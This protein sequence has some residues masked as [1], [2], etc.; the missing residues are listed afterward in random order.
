MRPHRSGLILAV[1]LSSVLVGTATQETAPQKA[2][3]APWV[4]PDFPFY[5][6]VLDARH[7]GVTLPATNL[8]PRALVLNLGD[9]LWA[10]FDPDLLRVAAMWRGDGVTPKALAPG[11]Y[12][13]PDKKTPGGQTPA[14]EPQGA[15]WVANGIY[16][17]WQAGDRLSLTD[18]REPAP[19]PEE[20]G[21]GPIPETTGRFNA[22]RIEPDRAV[23]EYLGRRR[24]HQRIRRFGSERWPALDRAAVSDRPGAHA[25]GARGRREERRRRGRPRLLERGR[26]CH[27][28]VVLDKRKP[29]RQRGSL[30]R[31]GGAARDTDRVFGPGERRGAP[32]RCRGRR[33]AGLRA[34]GDG[35]R[36]SRR[37]SRDRPR[38]APTSSTTSRC[39]TENPWRRSC[40][41]RRHPVPEGRHRRRRHARRRRLARAR[42]AGRRHH[43]ALAPVR[44]RPARTAHA[45]DPRR[46]DL[47][48]R[49][50]RHLAA[51]RHERR[52]RGGRHE[53][54]SNAFAQ[55]ADMREFPSTIRLA[56]SGEFVI[57]KGG[58]EATTIGKHNGSVLRV[59]GRRPDR[60]GARLRI[61]AAEPQRE[62]ADRPRDRERSAGPLHPD[63]RRCTSSATGSSTGS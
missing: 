7:A 5:S 40:P 59:S 11:S 48:L 54:F 13:V 56:P 16:P 22:I 37:R 57:A 19:S 47:R 9:G 44:L 33:R 29:R 60:D 18:P 6:S 43:C 24:Q 61:P 38:R 27:D 30:I 14:P 51:P 2:D 4:E 53:L 50:Q 15:V 41:A 10:A 52:R 55:T 3:L 1:V 49:S 17:G 20:V 12:H 26:W 8:S 36:K 34:R 25:S 35:L 42:A 46:A 21:R 62:P 32:V 58:Q 39:P 28:R 63:A 23:L 45:R 31:K